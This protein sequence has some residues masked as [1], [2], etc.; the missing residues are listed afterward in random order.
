MVRRAASTL[1]ACQPSTPDTAAQGQAGWGRRGASAR[2]RVWWEWWGM[3]YDSEGWDKSLFSRITTKKK[4][5]MKSINKEITSHSCWWVFVRHR[6]DHRQSQE[7]HPGT[8]DTL[9]F[10]FI[11]LRQL[12]FRLNTIPQPGAAPGT[13]VSRFDGY[14]DLLYNNY[15]AR[16]L[17][18]L[19]PILNFSVWNSASRSLKSWKNLLSRSSL[20][21]QNNC[22][23]FKEKKL[24]NF[25]YHRKSSLVIIHKYTASHTRRL[26]GVLPFSKWRILPRIRTACFARISRGVP[27]VAFSF[28]IISLLG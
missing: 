26:L 28:T 27:R 6:R 20:H 9:Q 1:F 24:S 25:V 14:V 15:A 4:L 10:C 21:C 3:M 2:L 12:N 16:C 7:L 11:I 18:F 23:W 8:I 22:P 17:D 19:L 5:R 13:A